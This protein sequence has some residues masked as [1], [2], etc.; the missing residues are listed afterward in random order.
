[1]K[2]NR[3][4]TINSLKTGGREGK[5]R[6]AQIVNAYYAK[7]SYFFSSSMFYLYQIGLMII[8]PPVWVFVTCDFSSGNNI[9]NNFN[10]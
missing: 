8:F 10:T 4:A 2:I 3:A 1:M 9:I 7:F 6:P 5:K